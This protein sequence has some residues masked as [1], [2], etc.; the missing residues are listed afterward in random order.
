MHKQK[1]LMLLINLFGGSAVVGSYILGLRAHPGQVEA[2]WGGVPAG[3]RPIYTANML[4]AAAGYLAL[5]IILMLCVDPEQARIGRRRFGTFN[6]LYLLILIP[7]AL[8][9]SQTYAVVQAYTTARWAAVLVTLVLV[10]L[11]SAGMLAALLRLRPRPSAWKYG[12]ALAGAFFLFL[13]TGVLDAIVW[14]LYYMN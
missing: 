14:P 11:G 7:S 13:Q 12:L 9:M 3:L 8:W 10:G 5:F 4:V 1:L 2:L 6:W